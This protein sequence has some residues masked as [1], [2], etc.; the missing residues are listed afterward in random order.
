MVKKDKAPAH[1]SADEI[2]AKAAPVPRPRPAEIDAVIEHEFYVNGAEAVLHCG[3]DGVSG[4]GSLA[5]AGVDALKVLTLCFLVVENGFI[6]TGTST[7]ESLEAYDE[8]SERKNARENARN[9]IWPLEAY[10]LR[11]ELAAKG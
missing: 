3:H 7:A 10:R 1:P 5:G 4:D 8:D 11:S 2:Q 6:V 9:K